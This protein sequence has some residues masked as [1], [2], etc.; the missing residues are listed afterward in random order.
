M[1]VD[2]RAVY[3]VKIARGWHT[4]SNTEY[5]YFFAS[6]FLGMNV[7]RD[8]TDRLSLNLLYCL[9]DETEKSDAPQCL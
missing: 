4:F 9:G 6:G 1:K 5:Q 7:H 2:K 3:G 8:S